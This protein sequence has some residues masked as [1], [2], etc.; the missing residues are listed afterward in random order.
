[1]MAYEIYR[2]SRKKEATA[3]DGEEGNAVLKEQ[4]ALWKLVMY[5]KKPNMLG[6]PSS[7]FIQYS[8]FLF[9]YLF[10]YFCY[11]SFCLSICLHN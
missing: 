6:Y 10:I 3:Q 2:Q 9:I 7:L 8:A 1:M 5:L 11:L 4:S